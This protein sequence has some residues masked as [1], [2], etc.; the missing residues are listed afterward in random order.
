MF[1][2]SLLAFGFDADDRLSFGL[3]HH[4]SPLISRCQTHTIDIVKNIRKC[5]REVTIF[6]AFNWNVQAGNDPTFL[7]FAIFSFS[8]RLLILSIRSIGNQQCEIYQS[9]INKHFKQHIVELYSSGATRVTGYHWAMP[10][11]KM[12]HPWYLKVHWTKIQS[13][14]DIFSKRLYSN[15]R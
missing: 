6:S 15:M 10:C 13:W 4:Y 8:L 5:F 9:H 7:T 11:Q 2:Y 12:L 1:T 3:V 14:W